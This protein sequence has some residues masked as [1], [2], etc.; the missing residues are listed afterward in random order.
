[1]TLIPTP[2]ITFQRHQASKIF[3]FLKIIPMMPSSSIVDV[4]LLILILGK[5]QILSR[6]TLTLCSKGRERN[7]CV[8]FPDLIRVKIMILLLIFFTQY[9]SDTIKMLCR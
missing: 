4:L 6:C 2:A 7:K 9:R 3:A 5:I 8:P 1:M